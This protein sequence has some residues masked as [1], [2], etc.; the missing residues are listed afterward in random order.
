MNAR[1]CAIPFCPVCASSTSSVS[2]TVPPAFSITRL[3]FASSSISGVFV[4]SRPAVSTIRTSSPRAMRRRH[5]VERHRAGV[6]ATLLRTRC[7]P[8]RSAQTSSCSPAAARNVS[9]PAIADRSAL[10]GEPGGELADRRGLPAPVHAHDEDHREP[11]ARSAA[12]RP[13]RAPRR[14]PGGAARRRRRRRDGPR[15]R[16][17]PGRRPRPGRRRPAA[18]ASSS[19]RQ[20]SSSAPVASSAAHLRAEPLAA[21]PATRRRHRELGRGGAVDARGDGTRRLARG[22]ARSPT[23]TTTSRTTIATSD[24]RWIHARRLADGFVLRHVD[25]SARRRPAAA[26]GRRRAGSSSRCATTFVVP[27]AFSEMP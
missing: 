4:W 15:G 22:R 12:A 2:S 23:T 6:R 7:A 3:I 14:S 27:S 10:A 20:A 16:A 18:A 5:R 21:E 8:A 1:A 24:R 19:S 11:A 17:P 25:D 9:A 26:V 13:G